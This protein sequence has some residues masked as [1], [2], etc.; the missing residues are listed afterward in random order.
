MTFVSDV[1]SGNCPL[2]ITRTYQAAD[3]CG[4]TSICTQIITVDDTVAPTFTF[5]PA[6]VTIECPAVPQFGTPAAEDACDTLVT[7]TFNDRTVAGMCPQE[8]TITR[9]WTATDDCGN[10]STA[11]QAIIVID[12]T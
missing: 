12:T 11:D 5:V 2:I 9:T 8:Y 1:W 7:I 3:S 6:D 4:N 10:S